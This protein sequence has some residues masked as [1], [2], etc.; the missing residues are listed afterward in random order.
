MAFVETCELAQRFNNAQQDTSL[1]KIRPL[2]PAKP[3]GVKL[4][5]VT[6]EHRHKPAG[7]PSV[8][9]M[10]IGALEDAIKR[11]QTG[12]VSRD[13]TAYVR[14]NYW[15]E[16][17]SSDVCNS[18]WH[19]VQSGKLVKEGDTYKLPHKWSLASGL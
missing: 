12:L 7:L 3:N 11:G 15:S 10:I 1:V 4:V 9:K 2:D 13:L 18:A 19:M 5:T 14:G 16:A 6:K 8:A 17:P